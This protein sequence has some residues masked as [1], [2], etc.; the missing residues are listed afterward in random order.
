[1]HS[2]P[3]SSKDR[4]GGPMQRGVKARWGMQAR[5]CAGAVR[6]SGQPHLSVGARHERLDHRTALVVQEVDLVDDEQT[7]GGGHRHL[8]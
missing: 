8:Q 5:G 2:C 3:R 7:H 1:M 4:S 6:P